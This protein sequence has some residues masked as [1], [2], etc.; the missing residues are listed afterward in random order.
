MWS[1][2]ED[3]YG[4]DSFEDDEDDTG[5]WNRHKEKKDGE[6][7]KEVVTTATCPFVSM[8]LLLSSSSSSTG[9]TTTPTTAW[10]HVDYRNEL[11]IEQRI[12][13]GGLGIVY[14]GWY[15]KKQ[16]KVAIKTLFF[17]PNIHSSLYSVCMYISIVAISSEMVLHTHD[18][19]CCC[20]PHYWI[21]FVG[22]YG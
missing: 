9:I 12:G 3:S 19:C 13:G 2:E 7:K 16:Q 11:Q 6:E 1:S 5:L 4:Y 10:T 18:G 15:P 21:F 22:V 8:P 17:D 20:S 14:Q